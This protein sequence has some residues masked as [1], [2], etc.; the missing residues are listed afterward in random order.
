M[1]E[2]TLSSLEMDEIFVFNKFLFS[3]ISEI[4]LFMGDGIPIISRILAAL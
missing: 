2:N 1:A 4:Y 3:S